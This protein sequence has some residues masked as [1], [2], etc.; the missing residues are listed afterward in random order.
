M[1]RAVLHENLED[2]AG[3][4]LEEAIVRQR[5]RGTSAGPERGEDVRDEV[6]LLVARLDGEVVAV[7]RLV[8]ALGAEGWIGEDVVEAVAAVRFVDGVV[9]RD[10]GLD[11]VEEKIHQRE[12]ARTRDEVLAEVGLRLDALRI[13]TVEDAFGFRDE[14]FVGAD[15]KAAG[16]ARR[17]ADF[18]VGLPARVGLHHMADGLDERAWREVLAR[19]LLPLLAAFSSKPSKAAPFTSTSI[20]DQSARR[21]RR[22]ARRLRGACAGCRRNGR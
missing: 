1:Q 13:G 18:E 6:E 14:P 10:V 2:F 16:A 17:V 19:T 9:E 22:A 5:E 20:A 8:R 12:P 21:C 4:A 15:E 3:L 7:G 11:A